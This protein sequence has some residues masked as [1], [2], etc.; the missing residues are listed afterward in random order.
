MVC[1]FAGLD[2]IVNKLIEINVFSPGG[3]FSTSTFAEVN[4]FDEMIDSIEHKYALANQ[5]PGGFT[6]QE[7]A[8]L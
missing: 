6:N 3:L 7:I 1:F 2:V 5:E 8:T 4:F